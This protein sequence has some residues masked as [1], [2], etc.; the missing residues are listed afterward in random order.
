LADK[1]SLLADGRYS[2]NAHE[3]KYRQQR[4]AGGR[5]GDGSESHGDT[6][7]KQDRLISRR[8]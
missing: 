4:A 7:R 5:S 1:R 3:A 8:M 2:E 6:H